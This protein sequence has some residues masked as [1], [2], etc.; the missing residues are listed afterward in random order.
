MAAELQAL[1]AQA[2]TAGQPARE[3]EEELS[4]VFTESGSLGLGLAPCEQCVGA[5]VLSLKP[6]TQATSHDALR[7]GL[8][9][10]AVGGTSVS[11]KSHAEVTEVILSHPERPLLVR[12]ASSA[13]VL[14]RAALEELEHQAHE[15]A[16]AVPD[17]LAHVRVV[18]PVVRDDLGD[19]VLQDEG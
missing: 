13:A 14:E 6:G 17:E 1:K 8:V 10:T 5:E 15:R 4:V 16:E 18:E 7:P 9:I 2:A 11:G 3:T 19:E 12:F